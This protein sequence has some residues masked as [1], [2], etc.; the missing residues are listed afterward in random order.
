MQDATVVVTFSLCNRCRRCSTQFVLQILKEV[1]TGPTRQ[2]LLLQ[3]SLLLS[4]HLLFV[5]AALTC[6]LPLALAAGIVLGMNACS[7]HNFIHQKENFRRSKTLA[8]PFL[9]N[10]N[11]L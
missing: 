7:A 2:M 10:K 1:G 9:Q 3:D 5:L 11:I 6:S 8:F 4:F